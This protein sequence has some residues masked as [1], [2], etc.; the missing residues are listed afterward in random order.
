MLTKEE[1]QRN[2]LGHAFVFTS[3]PSKSFV[4]KNTISDTFPDIYNCSA[5]CEHWEPPTPPSLISG[6]VPGTR[7]GTQL[8]PGFPSLAT[9]PYSATLGFHGVNV[10]NTESQRESMVV[11]LV[12]RYEGRKVEEVAAHLLGTRVFVAWPFLTEALVTS[13]SDEMFRYEPDVQGRNVSSS[14]GFAHRVVVGP[15][16][17]A[18]LD[19]FY[20]SAERIEGI[21]SKRWGTITGPVEVVVGV[22]LLKG[23]V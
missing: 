18:G 15:Q 14:G 7:L 19:K 9:I 8:L 17:E 12:N 1:K 13:L 2:S 11:T 10:F 3:D 22:R 5:V 6:V 4:Y 21:Y 23:K 16:T 20:E